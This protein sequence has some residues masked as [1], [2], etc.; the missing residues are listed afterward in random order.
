MGSEIAIVV[1]TYLLI[2]IVLNSLD[3]QN[4]RRQKSSKSYLNAL[5]LIV[6]WPILLPIFAFYA[7]V[8]IAG[9]SLKDD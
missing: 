8:F 6:S 4:N 2:G 1:S 3:S 7:C 9:S 5:L